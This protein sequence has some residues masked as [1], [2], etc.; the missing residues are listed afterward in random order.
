[1]TT[2]SSGPG[3]VTHPGDATKTSY[4]AADGP[5]RAVLA[6]VPDDGWRAPSPCEGW[7][8]ADVVAHLVTT[9]RDL[10]TGHGADLG[11]APDLD[12][13]PAGAWSV[14]A[15]RVL[16]ALG[17][18]ELPAT[19]FDGFFGPTTVGET[20]VRFYVWDMVV[21]RWDVARAAGLDAGLTAVELAQVE[22]GADGFGEALHMEG[23]C[24]PALDVGETATREQK[25]LGRL[26][27]RA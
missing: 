15:D 25:V 23:I 4:A 18:P 11:E 24:A 3:D 22:T 16:A 2:S 5:L 26:G 17:D 8:A 10:L 21:H 12:V 13:D 9:Q 1:M 7:T 6:A 19:T 20:L 14:H 27:R